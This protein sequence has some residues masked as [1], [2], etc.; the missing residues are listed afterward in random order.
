[1]PAPTDAPDRGVTGPPPEASPKEPWAPGPGD[2]LESEE[3]PGVAWD[4]LEKLG[5][6]RALRLTVLG[7]L[8]G[9]VEFFQN[10]YLR[11]SRRRPLAFAVIVGSFGLAALVVWMSLLAKPQLLALLKVL[12]GVTAG[13]LNLVIM[14]TLLLTPLLVVVNVYITA[15]LMHLVLALLKRNRSGFEATF[16]VAAYSFAAFVLLVVPVFGTPVAF[17]WSVTI[18]VIGLMQAQGATAGLAAGAVL[19]PYLIVLLLGY[20]PLGGP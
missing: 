2:W 1:S 18:R 14:L 10:M 13:Q 17:F 8:F 12:F 11:G 19:W 4:H 7:A 6:W 16:R 5:L 15:A 3:R 9:P 20:L